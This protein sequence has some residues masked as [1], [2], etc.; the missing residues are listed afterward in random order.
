MPTLCICQ[1]TQSSIPPLPPLWTVQHWGTPW[2]PPWGCCAAGCCCKD[3][4]VKVP[5]CLDDA[6]NVILINEYMAGNGVETLAGNVDDT[7]NC[8]RHLNLRFQNHQTKP[9]GAAVLSGMVKVVVEEVW[10]G[11]PNIN[12]IC[13]VCRC[14]LRALVKVFVLGEEGVDMLCAVT[15]WNGG[16]QSCCVKRNHF[17]IRA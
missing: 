3:L 2:S 13:D 14:E 6:P 1:G 11:E 16:E 17:L 7:I 8:E 5:G 12:R 10:G 15:D 9:Y 4:G